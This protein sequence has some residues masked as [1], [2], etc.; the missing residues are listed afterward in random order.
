[1]KHI[2]RILVLLLILAGICPASA[3]TSSPSPAPTGI[4]TSQPLAQKDFRGLWVSTVVNID[5]P[6]KP[7]TDSSILISEALKIL[8][9]ARDMGMNAIFLQVRPT[10]DAIY[11]SKYF[12]WSKYLTGKQGVAPSAGFDPLAFWIT[13]AHKRGMELHAWINPYR[14]T[15]KSQGEPNH[16]FA[17][18]ALNNPARLNPGWVVKHSDGCLYFNPAIPEVRKLI[19]DGVLEIINNYPVDGIHF[20]DYFYPDT[21]FN[22]QASYRQYNVSGLSLDD[23]RRD[24]VNTLIRDVNN[25]IKAAGK[26]IRFGI[27]PFGIWANKKTNPLGSD[28]NGMESYISHYADS[29]KWVKE[30]IIDYIAPQIYWNIGYSIADY[31]KLSE[32][33]KRVVAGTN[34]DLYI[35]QAAYK[36]CGTDPAAPWYGPEE[37]VRQI[38]LN[39]KS[40]E[41]KGSIFFSY[42]S[43]V[44]QP[45]L[46]AAVK[47]TYEQRDGKTAAIPITVGRPT[48][49]LRTSFTSYFISGAS[50]PAKPLY[51]NGKLVE[52][53]SSQGY[54]GLLMP[55]SEGANSFTVSQEA[56]YATCL[57]Y[58]NKAS[59]PQKMSK[60]EIPVASTFPQSQEYRMPG[61]K[62]T[63]SCQAPIGSKVTV[64]INGK[65]YAMKAASTKA[66]GSGLYPTTYSCVYAIPSFSGAPR[67]LDLGNPVYTVNYNGTVKSQ[68]APAKV[69]VIMKDSPYYAQVIEPIAFTFASPSSEPGGVHELYSGMLDLVTGMTGSY[70]RLSSGQWVI[71]SS[72]KIYTAKAKLQSVIKNTQYLTGDKWDTLKLD[73]SDPVP[74]LATFDGSVL[75]I[76][77]SAAQSGATPKLPDNS[78]F[79]AIKAEKSANGTVYSLTVK[80]DQVIQGYY[81]EKT[82][83]GLE[84]R[85]KRKTIAAAGGQPLS[86]ITVMVDPGHGGEETGAIGPLGARFAEK[87]INLQTALKLQKELEALGAKVLM[88]RTTDATVSLTDR[89][90]ANRKARP[91]MFISVHSNA[92]EDNVDVSKIDGFSVYYREAFSKTLSDMVYSNTLNTLNRSAK[93]THVKNFYVIRGTWVP[94]ILLETGFV[95]N[96][97]EFEWLTDENAQAQLAKN[98]AE[99]VKAYFS[100]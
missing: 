14:V 85:I 24:N 99:S 52:N 38:A 13:E 77:V 84:L 86:G 21:T 54:Y 41:I 30:G 47:A 49:R 60:V 66:S 32:W 76:N 94:S 46:Y 98:I 59:T 28:T 12:P 31:S 40:P 95:T 5:Y 4:A 72:V 58:R 73:L 79:S 37:I 80:K 97:N 62:I 36:A 48:E 11:P 22:D 27:S 17:S 65:S 20:D 74:G 61:E 89:L 6:S 42:K 90:N 43:F 29:Y 87:D 44:D 26:P 8:D 93:G 7:N 25:A 81:V 10:A 19:V 2:A 53:R 1:M 64:K 75:K 55:L 51:I 56:S 67:N 23:W 33:W 92:M 50:D 82:A 78:L 9:N 63:L 68:K 15:K 70:A 35:G 91:D 18:L 16:D 45:S 88:T 96:P 57:I 83:S 100:N 34:V 3:E 69:G 71:K 39:Q